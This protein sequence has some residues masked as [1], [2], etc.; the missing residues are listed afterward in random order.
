MSTA[1]STTT[2]RGVHHLVLFCTD[3]AASRRWY[4]T[5]GFEYLRGYHGM[6]W[7]RLGDAEIMLHPSDVSSAFVKSPGFHAAGEDIDQV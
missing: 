4:E 2:F 6:Y 7:S 3:T 1:P 5:V